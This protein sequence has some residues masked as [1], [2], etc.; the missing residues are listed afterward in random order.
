MRRIV[1]MLRDTKQLERTIIVITGDHG[2]RHP[3]ESSELF[4]KMELLS[5][6]SYHV[7]F[8]LY[9][10]GRGLLAIPSKAHRTL[11]S[12]RRFLIFWESVTPLATTMAGVCSWMFRGISSSLEGSTNR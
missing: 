11:T 7:P 6:V 8:L 10:G 12:P 1:T 5:P 4:P 2:L 9:T 3:M